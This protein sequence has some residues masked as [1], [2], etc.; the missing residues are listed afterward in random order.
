[1]ASNKT[2]DYIR[3]HPNCLEESSKGGVFIR[4]KS[5]ISGKVIEI[6]KRTTTDIFENQYVK[7]MI[8][9]IIKRL[10]HIEKS[11]LNIWMI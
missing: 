11:I 10:K 2:K 4:G 7:Y 1:M 9:N 3:K 6:Q 8:V 5:Y